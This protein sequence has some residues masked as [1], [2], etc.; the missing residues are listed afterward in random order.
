MNIKPYGK[1]HSLDGALTSSQLSR[2]AGRTPKSTQPNQTAPT[3]APVTPR[4]TVAQRRVAFKSW[5]FLYIS[6]VSADQRLYL[7]CQKNILKIAFFFAENS[8]QFKRESVIKS[9]TFQKNIKGR[10]W[11]SCIDRA[12]RQLNNSLDS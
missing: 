8:I 9:F 7:K 10:N 11:K 5:I 6:K 12:L 4:I 3:A 1:R 2:E